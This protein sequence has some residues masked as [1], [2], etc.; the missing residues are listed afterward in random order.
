M[1]FVVA[2]DSMPADSK[3]HRKADWAICSEPHSRKTL[4]SNVLLEDVTMNGHAPGI[5]G[6]WT[7]IFKVSSDGAKVVREI[8]GATPEGTGTDLKIA[9]ETLYKVSRRRSVAF[10]LSDFFASG[11][12]RALSLAAARHDVVPIV[13]VDPRDETLPDVGLATFEDFETGAEVLVD[14]SDPRVREHSARVRRAERARHLQ[15]FKKFGLD[16][17][18]V[19]TDAPYIVPLRDLFARRAK[20]APR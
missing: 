10:V 8:L 4:L 11:Y 12:E 7:G 13:I 14:T 3:R 18:V 16:H 15:L 19:R 9:L 1:S 2:V 20:R 17:C 5:T 6:E